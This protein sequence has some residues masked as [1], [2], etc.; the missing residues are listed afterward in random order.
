MNQIKVKSI[1]PKERIPF[2]EWCVMFKVSTRYQDRT[3]IHNAERIMSL[4]DGYLGTKRIYVK[5]L[6]NETTL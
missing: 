3:C 2:N 4:W 1:Y 6:S 5:P